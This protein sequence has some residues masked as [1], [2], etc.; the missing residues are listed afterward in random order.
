M[1]AFIIT[2]GLVYLKLIKYLFKIMPFI[3]F[4]RCFETENIF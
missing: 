4:S 1:Q 3:L 2:E